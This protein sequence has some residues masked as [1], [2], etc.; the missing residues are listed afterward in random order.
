MQQAAFTLSS[1]GCRLHWWSGAAQ[2][3]CC[4]S[5]LLGETICFSVHAPVGQVLR[6]EI[7]LSYHGA[8]V[9]ALRHAYA[10]QLFCSS[11]QAIQSCCSF[12]RCLLRCKHSHCKHCKHDLQ[13]CRLRRWGRQRSR[14][15]CNTHST[16]EEKLV[17]RRNHNV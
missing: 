14:S 12:A 11:I 7:T 8:D 17:H 6:A 4:M 1:V 13:I 15:L 10:W 16:S 2:A 9:L 5:G 3:P